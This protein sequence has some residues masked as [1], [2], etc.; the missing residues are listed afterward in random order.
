[1]GFSHDHDVYCFV[2]GDSVRQNVHTRVMRMMLVT[3]MRASI[4]LF[5]AQ[6]NGQVSQQVAMR[7]NVLL[8]HPISKRKP[9]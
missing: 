4:N 1:M 6:S 8:R 9:Q 7:K 5:S 3:G 2:D